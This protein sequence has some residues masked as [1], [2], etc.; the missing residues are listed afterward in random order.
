MAKKFEKTSYIVYV[1]NWHWNNLDQDIASLFNPA[2]N[3]L[4]N[5][6]KEQLIYHNTKIFKIVFK[7]KRYK[8][9]WSRTLAVI[10]AIGACTYYSTFMRSYRC[11]VYITSVNNV[12]SPSPFLAECESL[13]LLL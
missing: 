12:K 6:H 7:Q 11:Y 8:G 9:E 4:I 3:K 13:I 1:K 5:K 10:K 2:L